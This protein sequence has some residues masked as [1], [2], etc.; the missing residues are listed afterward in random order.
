MV[1][2]VLLLAGTTACLVGA[3]SMFAPAETEAG[4]GIA[5]G[6]D[7]SLI[8]ELRA[9]GGG[10]AG[11][12]IAIAAGAFSA[13]LAYAAALLGTL[14]YLG[15]AAARVLSMAIDGRPDARLL[16]VLGAEILIGLLCLRAFLKLRKARRPAE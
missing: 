11:A 3:A 4:L 6:A 15:F 14:T 13:E 1:R 2:L 10:L 16:I 12:G 9:S 8:N 7:V 5:I